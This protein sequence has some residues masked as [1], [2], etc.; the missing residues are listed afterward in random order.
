[1]GEA[2]NQHK[3]SKDN[4]H[5]TGFFKRR[6]DGQRIQRYRCKQCQKSFSQATDDP[7]YYQKKRQLNHK[8][9]M[10]LASTVS[11]RRTAIIL[12]INPKTVARKLEWLSK[13]SQKKLALH[14]SQLKT[15]TAIQ[16]DELQ[17]SEHSKC[18]PLSVALA[19]SKDNRKICGFYVSKMPAT[20]HLAAISRKK[21]GHR[22]DDRIKGLRQLFK[23]LQSFLDPEI[24]IDSDDC[25]Y[26]PNIVNHYFPKANYSQFKG[27]A[28][29]ISGQGELKKIR[30]DPL[31]AINHT[32]A[33]CRANINRLIRKT[34]CT[35]KK[36]ARLIDHLA[37][38]AWVH[39]S[40]LTLTH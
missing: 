18:K 13:Q 11:M 31:F 2:G 39:N 3:C 1:M 14:T 12:N 25:A 28:S 5:K 8:C 23:Q 30:R 10:M 32:L 38:Y 7:A 35:T 26:Y 4:A 22:R 6:S 24:A 16:F 19:V 34:W 40:R 29:S 33:M 20:G 21:Y 27:K 37:I 36:I 17:T 15:V 9:L